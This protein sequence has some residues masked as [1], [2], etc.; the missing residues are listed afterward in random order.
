MYALPYLCLCKWCLSLTFQ[1]ILCETAV[2]SALHLCLFESCVSRRTLM[3]QQ[4]MCKTCVSCVCQVYVSP[5]IQLRMS[6]LCVS[7]LL[8]GNLRCRRAP[9][10][11]DVTQALFS[12]LNK[13]TYP[14]MWHVQSC[15][16][17]HLSPSPSAACPDW[18]GVQHKPLTSDG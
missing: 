9:T 3:L 18:P 14:L 10:A 13:E 5:P 8:K 2:S 17:A 4:S 12:C 7:N 11:H 6:D 16:V 15:A 1:L